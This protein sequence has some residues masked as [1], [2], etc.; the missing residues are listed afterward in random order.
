MPRKI[1]TQLRDL[2]DSG[3]C[4]WH[5]TVDV[6]PVAGSPFH[7]SS[8]EEMVDGVQYLAQ[9]DE[10][11]A[12]EMSLTDESEQMEF[13]CQNVDMVMG[14]TITGSENLLNGARGTIGV[15]FID[16][17]TQTA[18]ADKKMPTD[19]VTGEVTDQTVAF[20]LV[21][22]IDTAIIAGRTFAS[23]FPWRE[24]VASQPVFNPSTGFGGGGVG[25]GRGDP[26]VDREVGRGGGR[27]SP[28]DTGVVN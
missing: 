17:E 7:L 4:E 16:E 15:V 18:Y 21:S 26:G 27:Y 6:V 25:E 5:T 20:K 23:V 8:G 19:L 2:L 24:P 10:V 1:S 12:L 14:R 28:F 3:H 22:Q 9:L 13:K 11:N